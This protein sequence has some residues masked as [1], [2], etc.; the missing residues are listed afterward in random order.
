[1]NADGSGKRRLTT[2]PG[3]DTQPCFS[4]DGR[5]IVFASNRA[6][7][8]RHLHDER[9]RR[10]SHPPDHR[11]GQRHTAVLLPRRQQDRLRQPPLRQLVHRR[12]PDERGRQRPDP[13]RQRRG[14]R[15][16]AHLLPRRQPD[17]LRPHPRSQ[18]KPLCRRRRR[19]RAGR[20]HAHRRRRSPA[21]LLARRQPDRLRQPPRRPL[22]DL[23]DERHRRRGDEADRQAGEPDARLL[24]RRP[25]DRLLQRRKHLHDR[26]PGRRA[27]R[28]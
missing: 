8:L 23:H 3:D 11:S 20:A 6:R 19:R 27:N 4:A 1:M 14:R 12:L 25:P 7:Q 2:D 21:V 22:R 17:R 9:G 13:H 5:R 16:D 10:R 28:G 24:P 26:R 15:R 18:Q